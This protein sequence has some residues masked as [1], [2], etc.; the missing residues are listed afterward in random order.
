[1]NEAG[2]ERSPALSFLIDPLG[3]VERRWRFMAAAAAVVLVSTAGFVF[4]MVHS[5]ESTA[6]VLITQPSQEGAIPGAAS[7]PIAASNAMVAEVL[8]QENLARTIEHYDLYASERANAP[9]SEIVSQMRAAITIEPV[10]SFE[11]PSGENSVT[12][13]VSYRAGDRGTAAGVANTL[14][15]LFESVGVERRS[16]QLRAETDLLAQQVEANEKALAEQSAAVAAFRKRNRSSLPANVASNRKQ[17]AGLKERQAALTARIDEAAQAVA[18]PAPEPAPSTAPAPSGSAKQQAIE[19]VEL[20]RQLARESAIYTDEHPNIQSL[21]WRIQRLETALVGGAPKRAPVEATPEPSEDVAA[22]REE[23]AGVESSIATLQAR[24]SR[25]SGVG[26][27]LARLEKREG[28][29]RQVHLASLRTFEDAVAASLA[30]AR[31]EA[32]VSILEPATLSRAPL[33]SRR[34]VLFAGLGLSLVLA[35]GIAVL[36]EWI[37]PVVLGTQQ[38]H[39]IAGRPALGCLPRLA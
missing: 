11:Q 39:R 16:G 38:L 1:M 21:R 6:T 18:T 24:V 3:V 27:E 28:E 26:R 9:M 12:Y 37:D 14:A 8:S 34:S 10:D 33:R 36:L 4:Q 13:A 15:G 31:N 25:T 22:L 29:L 23:L 5:Y 2:D 7:D 17:L 35:A 19:L 32:Q 30:S 20:R